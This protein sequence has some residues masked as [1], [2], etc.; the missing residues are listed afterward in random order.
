M[1]LNETYDDILDR[2]N[3]YSLNEGAV[4]N[5]TK[6]PKIL[7]ELYALKLDQKLKNNYQIVKIVL[8]AMIHNIQMYL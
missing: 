6:G 1:I 5:A 3:N 8:L 2:L 4:G 7:L